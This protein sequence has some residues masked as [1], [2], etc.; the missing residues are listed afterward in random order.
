MTFKM[1]HKLSNYSRSIEVYGNHER[2]KKKTL[3]LSP[4]PEIDH[5]KDGRVKKETITQSNEK[6]K[7]VDLENNTPNISPYYP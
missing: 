7:K 6:K 4:G 5:I 1:L 3:L 2:E